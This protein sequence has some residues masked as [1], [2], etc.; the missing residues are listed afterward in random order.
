[1]AGGGPCVGHS[2]HFQEHDRM[3]CH[4]CDVQYLSHFGI[5]MFVGSKI[6]FFATT[7]KALMSDPMRHD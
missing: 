4:V 3:L 7:E 5:V 6:H 1:M 2:Q